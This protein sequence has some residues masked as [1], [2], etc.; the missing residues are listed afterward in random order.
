MRRRRAERET[1]PTAA[2]ASAL[3]SANVRDDA[4]VA[5]LE[6]TVTALEEAR[7]AF[8]ADALATI[9]DI[10]AGGENESVAWSSATVASSVE[11]RERLCGAVVR[12]QRRLA[13][14]TTATRR[15][16]TNR[17]ATET[18]ARRRGEC[19]TGPTRRTRAR[20]RG[21]AGRPRRPRR[22]TSHAPPSDSDSGEPAR[23]RRST[24]DLARLP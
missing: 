19:L 1:G 2:Q 3:A 6:K 21:V 4:T 16:L 14:T 7:A 9:A 12:T 20:P 13:A 11:L 23:G 24:D 5:E 18:E 22:S 8:A 15:H 17:R 10:E